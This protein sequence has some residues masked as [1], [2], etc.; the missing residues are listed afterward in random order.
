M[1]K[2][3]I[4]NPCKQYEKS[5]HDSTGVSVQEE[6]V[7]FLLSELGLEVE[8]KYQLCQYPTEGCNPNLQKEEVFQEEDQ[9]SDQG[10]Q[11]PPVSPIQELRHR[12][13]RLSYSRIP[14][15]WRR[16]ADDERVCNERM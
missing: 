14:V 1:E 10:I 13:A 15:Y 6:K 9:K 11:T 7:K 4:R 3:T 5:Q 2:H 12:L 16:P 8:D